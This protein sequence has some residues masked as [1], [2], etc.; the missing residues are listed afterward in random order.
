MALQHGRTRYTRG[1]RY[2]VC[3]SAERDYQRNRYRRQ[4]GL[5]GDW[6]DPP[7]LNVIDAPAISSHDGSVVA[8]VRAELDGSAGAVE[9]PGLAA[10]AIALA[11]ILDD[12]RHVPTQPAAARQ[13]ATI[14]DV[15]S[16]RSHRR[17]KLAAVKS[18][19]EGA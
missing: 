9:R 14:L 1:C 13:L 16:R 3:K 5:P 17:G 18:M 19:T 8:A 2:A 11:E 15:L 12:P 6:P 10:V 4:R 7:R